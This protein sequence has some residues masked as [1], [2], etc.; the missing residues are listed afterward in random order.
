MD[1]GGY[2]ASMSRLIAGAAIGK[3]FAEPQAIKGCAQIG[4][5]TGVDEYAVATLKFEGGILAQLACGIKLQ[6][7][8]TV[9]IWGTE[10]SLVVPVPW[11]PSFRGNFSKLILFKEGVP[12]EILIECDQ[13][14]YTIEADHVAEHLAER[15]SPAMSWEDTLGNMRVLDIWQASCTA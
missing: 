13:D 7:E 2:T 9:R 14:L 4:A 15:Q 1:V 10:G 11:H 12:E 5:E 6:L 8:N 3:P